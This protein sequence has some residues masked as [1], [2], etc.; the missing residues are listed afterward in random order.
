MAAQY[1]SLLR[2]Q[3]KRHLGAA[4]V[5]PPEWA[6]FLE[7]VSQAYE[8][9]DVD[10]KMV[11]RSMDLS[12]RELHEANRGLRLA[13]EAAE[14][15]ALA[16]GEFLANMSHEIRTPMNA[17]IGLTALLLDT[18]VDAEQREYL[19]TV[20]TAGESLLEIINDILDFSR[21][22]SRRLE[23]ERVP[24]DMRGCVGASVELFA[25]RAAEADLELICRVDPNVPEVVLGDSTRI[26]QILLNLV[27]NAMKFTER[28]SVTVD[29]TVLGTFEELCEIQFAVRD[30]GIGIPA[31]KLDRL[32]QS[33]SQVDCSTTRKYGGTGLGLTISLR[34]SELM[35]G[36][37]W[38]ESVEG[39][40]STFYF[41]IRVAVQQGPPAG[42]AYAGR[43]ALVADGHAEAREMLAEM[44][45]WMGVGV[46]VAG[47]AAEVEAALVAGQFDLLALD[48]QTVSP[49]VQKQGAGVATIVLEKPGQEDDGDGEWL[50]AAHLTK[51]VRE[52]PLRAALEGFWA[53]VDAVTFNPHR[54][55]DADGKLGEKLPLRILLAEDNSVNQRVM[56]KLLERFGYQADLAVT[57]T[58]ALAAT[59]RTDYDLVLMDVHMPEMDGL[60][61]ARRIRLRSGGSAR[62]RIVALTASA[63]QE[64]RERCLAA[65]MDS[66]A[67][68]PIRVEDLRQVL[69]ECSVP[70]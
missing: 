70:V 65:G 21:I 50:E 2:R 6:V 47:S 55:R 28:G 10:R 27:G 37:M 17:V 43:R 52:L 67:T 7:S 48:A 23:V 12:S 66:Y 15:A 13:K 57:G 25:L 64:D 19:E 51:P 63:L 53:D 41:T 3:L 22:E 20:R 39:V 5:V 31:D 69:E 4:A 33:F 40:G 35:G 8:Q 42:G 1:H 16:K 30:T 18:D 32:F 54:E 11:E 49:S 9:A 36:R 56:L 59:A 29:V 62:P 14:R 45:R 26:R 61:A 58:Q 34:L 38:L 44:L 24:V 60:E 46:T 68:K